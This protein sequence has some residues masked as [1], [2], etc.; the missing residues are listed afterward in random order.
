MPW[1]TWTLVAYLAV[2]SLISIVICVYDKIISK[3]NRVALRV[4]E[5][6]LFL[7]SALGGSAAMY[8]CMLIVR[9]KTKHIQFMI[10]IPAIFLVQA[11]VIA[12][13]FWKEI[14]SFV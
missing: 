11:G 2:I 5:A 6:V 1:L 3:L 12:V 8:V 4:P 7:L 10:G 13:L 14:L 9:H